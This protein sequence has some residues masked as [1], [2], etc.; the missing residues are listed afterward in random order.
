MA[1]FLG[2]K[3]NIHAWRET[4]ELIA[5]IKESL[6]RQMA[7]PSTG[8]ALSLLQKLRELLAGE[9]HFENDFSAAFAKT[10]QELEA[11]NYYD[12]LPPLHARFNRLAA[13]YFQHRGSVVAL[14][15]LCNAYRDALV[16]KALDLV[17][18][19]M[20]ADDLRTP[21]VPFGLFAAG[22]VGREEQTLGVAADYFLVHVDHAPLSSEY[23][24][25]FSYR[26]MAVLDSC[27]MLRNRR[28]KKLTDIFWYGSLG[29][30]QNLVQQGLHPE[31]VSEQPDVPPVPA[32]ATPLEMPVWQLEE[33]HRMLARLADL[34]YIRCNELLADQVAGIARDTIAAERRSDIMPA[35]AR[36]I[37]GMP[38]ALGL[39]RGLRTE[40]RGEQKGN[41]NLEL[42]AIAP[43]TMGIRMLA[44]IH[45]IERTGTIDRIKGLLA[46]GQLD[47][48]LADRLLKAYHEFFTL[49]ITME[50]GTSIKGKNS[51]YLAPGLL[52]PNDEQRLKNGLEAVMTLQKIVYQHSMGQE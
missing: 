5:S 34:R 3:G 37:A 1:V 10:V 41:I 52:S 27:G 47:V 35:L 33:R 13:G 4:S 2:A 36:R 21:P 12:R 42:H 38:V 16:G 45:G 15:S 22:A 17:E 31:K 24:R 40:K 32:T 30:W 29:D 44:M 43:M 49:K 25:Q 50:M 9:L 18:Q 6:D 11:V 46:G 48:E 7:Q 51:L 23:F 19:G 28:R 39:F 14:H 26:I 8:D 20:C